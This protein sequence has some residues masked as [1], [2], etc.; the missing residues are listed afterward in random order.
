[1]DVRTTLFGTLVVIAIAASA[2]AQTNALP[3][4]TIQ[5]SGFER[6]GDAWYAKPDNPPFDI[7]SIKGTTLRNSII[8]P[9]GMKFSGF[10]LFDVLEKKCGTL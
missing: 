6:R 2:S 9:G 7:G 3:P 10:Y 8:G 4:N 1:M 5:C